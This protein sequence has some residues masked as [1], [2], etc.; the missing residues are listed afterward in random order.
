MIDAPLTCKEF[1]EIVTAYCDHVLSPV[2]AERFEAHLAI[3]PSCQEYLDQILRTVSLSGR[4]RE[5]ALDPGRREH[6][7]SCFRE[8]TSEPTSTR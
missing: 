6:L 8:W 1:V 2:D 3:C 5:T 7:L 4:L